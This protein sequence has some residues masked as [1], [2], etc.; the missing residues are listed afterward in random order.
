MRILLIHA[1]VEQRDVGTAVQ[2]GVE[3]NVVGLGVGQGAG[4]IGG[5]CRG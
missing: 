5:G 2:V 1:I 3:A 4:L